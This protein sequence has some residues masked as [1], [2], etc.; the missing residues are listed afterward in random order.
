MTKIFI[1]VIIAII[2][3]FDMYML[4]FKGYDATI[5]WE[6]YKTSQD[7]M[8]IPVIVGVFVGHLFFPHRHVPKKPDDVTPPEPPRAA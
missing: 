3:V 6:I 5:S 7:Y 1:V 4:N 8:I 2:T